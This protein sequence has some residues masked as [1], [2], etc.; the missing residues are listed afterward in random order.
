MGSVVF[1]VQT[2]SPDVCIL[3]VHVHLL[4][5]K[6]MGV[7]IFKVQTRSPGAFILPVHVH[8]LAAKEMGVV[9]FKVQTRSPGAFVFRIHSCKSLK[10]YLIII[11]L[12]VSKRPQAKL[13][14]N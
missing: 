4:A 7:V 8:L 13:S 12:G 3:P 5:A 2:R 14:V 6:E 9:I 11:P 1:K 10:N